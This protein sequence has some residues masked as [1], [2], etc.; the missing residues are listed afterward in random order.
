MRYNRRGLTLAEMMVVI[1][2]IGLVATAVVPGLNS[3]FAVKQQAAVKNIARSYV[4]MLETAPIQNCSFR[5]AFKRRFETIR[6]DSR[7][8]NFVSRIVSHHLEFIF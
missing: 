8:K 7:K 6:D 1:L 5:I 2:L 3:I 4:W